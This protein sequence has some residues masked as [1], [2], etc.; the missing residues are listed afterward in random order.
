MQR[1]GNGSA[2]DTR[3]FLNTLRKLQIPMS[4]LLAIGIRPV[5]YIESFN[6]LRAVANSASYTVIARVRCLH[7]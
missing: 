4:V 3:K 5:G 7:L 2:G 1:D 6:E